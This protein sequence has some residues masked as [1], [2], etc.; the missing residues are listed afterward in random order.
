MTANDLETGQLLVLAAADVDALLPMRDAIGVMDAA[1]RALACGEAYNP[2]RFVV[3][4]PT[5]RG[6]LG[7]MPAYRE[8]YGLKE[9]CV[10]PSN[11]ALGLDPHQGAVL[12]HEPEAGVLRAVINAS[13]VTAVRTAAVS[14]VATQALARPDARTLALLGSGVQARSH[15]EAMLCVRPIERVRVWSRTLTR[16]EAFVEQSRAATQVPIIVCATVEEALHGADLVVTATA[17]IEPIVQRDWLAPGVHLNAVG[18]SIPTSRELDARTMA[19]STLIVDSR[20]SVLNESGDYLFAA[21]AGLIDADH[22]RA[23]LGEVLVGSHP[24]RRSR[25][26]ITVFESLGIAVEDLAAAQALYT[27]AVERGIGT[28]VP[29]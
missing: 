10:F 25:E 1:L 18:S 17:A 26:E 3:R 2:L 23:E 14:A 6:L 12:L 8:G 19:A 20:E 13:A 29:F 28:R 4:P 15:L 9:V 24:G 27:R 5:G 7:L 11:S 22:I 16:A 21:R